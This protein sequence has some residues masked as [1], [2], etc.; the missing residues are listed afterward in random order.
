MIVMIT[1]ITPSV[2]ASSRPFSI[3][4][5]N[6]RRGPRATDRTRHR[7]PPRVPRSRPAPDEIRRRVVLHLEEIGNEGLHEREELRKERRFAKALEV[8][9][10]RAPVDR[11]Q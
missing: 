4:L 2:K 11:Q 9:F 6:A 8:V 10:G 5:P 3:V 1:A 7:A